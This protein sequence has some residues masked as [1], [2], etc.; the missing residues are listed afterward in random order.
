MSST[1]STRRSQLGSPIRKFK[2][3]LSDLGV[4]VN[5]MTPAEFASYIA[6][7]TEK[8]AK[9]VKFADIKPE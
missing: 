5:P 7:E 1:R 4:V 6:T 2:A 3:R 9:V 8:W